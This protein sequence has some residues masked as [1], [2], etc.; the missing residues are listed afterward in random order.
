MVVA[1]SNRLEAISAEIAVMLVGGVLVPLE[2][3]TTPETV[4]ATANETGPSSS[5]SSRGRLSTPLSIPPGLCPGW[6]G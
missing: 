6:R 5:S 2:F 4:T 3:N 1:S